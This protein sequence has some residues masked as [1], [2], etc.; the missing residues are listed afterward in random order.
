MSTAPDFERVEALLRT[1]ESWSQQTA[2]LRS[3]VLRAAGTA[4][5]RTRN[6]RAD[7]RWW[8]LVCVLV[9]ATVTVSLQ[10]TRWL[11]KVAQ[12]YLQPRPWMHPAE[13]HLLASQ[14]SQ[15]AVQAGLFGYDTSVIQADQYWRKYCLNA[16]MG[17]WH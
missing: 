7:A 12:S 8:F 14:S 3:R 5:F 4:H 15:S 16:L 2:D 11:Q 10:D 1:N 13:A 9:F 17:V 6:E